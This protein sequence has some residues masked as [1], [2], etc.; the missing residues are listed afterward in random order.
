[1]AQMQRSRPKWVFMHKHVLKLGSRIPASVKRIAGNPQPATPSA[2][3]SLS[4]PFPQPATPSALKDAQAIL[5][6]AIVRR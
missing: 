1:M 5:N 3:H 6:Y 4:Q 2:S